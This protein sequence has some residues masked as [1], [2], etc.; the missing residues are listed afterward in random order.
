MRSPGKADWEGRPQHCIHIGDVFA[1][2][3][4][5]VVR[6]VLGSC[7]AVC[8]R[9]PAAKVGGMNHFMLPRAAQDQQGGARYGVH[10][11]ELLIN[12]CMKHGGDR[13]CLEAKV[14]GGGH[15][16][17]IRR[18]ESDVPQ[19]NIRF[20][21]HFLRTE[22]IPLVSSDLGGSVA[23]EVYFF[24]DNGRVLLKRLPCGTDRNRTLAA[25]EREERATLTRPPA[26]LEDSNITLF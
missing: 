22:N 16:L 8:L 7:I 18:T 20:I 19:S 23:R 9:D 13:R 3:R 25:V 1:G 26:P 12:A 17:R 15:V 5:T 4:P 6:T 10:A 24:T 14:F 21:L 11:M 2:S